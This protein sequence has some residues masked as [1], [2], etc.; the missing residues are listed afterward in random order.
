MTVTSRNELIHNYRS[1]N[2]IEKNQKFFEEPSN[3][4]LDDEAEGILTLRFR[5]YLK[6]ISVTYSPGM[7]CTLISFEN[8]D[9]GEVKL[10]DKKYIYEDSIDHIEVFLQR[11]LFMIDPENVKPVNEM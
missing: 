5:N 2:E 3:K 7:P 6:E 11:Q 8:L 1:F 4:P 10:L 9:K